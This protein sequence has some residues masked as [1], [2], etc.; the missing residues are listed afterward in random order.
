L[1]QAEGKASTE[2]L[3][4]AMVHYRTLFEELVSESKVVA[5]KAG[6]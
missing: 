6:D 4:L 5:A 2:E 3:R 1:R